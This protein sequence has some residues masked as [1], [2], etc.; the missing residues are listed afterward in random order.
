MKGKLYVISGP[1]GSGKGT[2]IAEL[3]KRE[4]NLYLSVSVTTRKMRPGEQEGVNYYY[5]TNEQFQKM[6]DNNEFLEYE[7]FCTNSYGTPLAPVMEKLSKGIDVILEIEV[8]GARRVKE[9]MPEA[10]MV[11][12]A[13]PSVEEL[14]KRLKGRN[15]ET[16]DV[17]KLRIATAKEEL[18]LASN[19]DY[20]V[21][22]DI[23]E[24]STDDIHSIIKAEKCKKERVID[25]LEVLK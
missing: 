10:V 6:K 12:I 18:K 9:K 5:R 13:P 21:V 4:E 14:E 1:S 8:K 25:E 7:E 20:I 22:N 11:F 23:V 15:T 16:D 3:L 19:Y 17:I 24:K 2:V